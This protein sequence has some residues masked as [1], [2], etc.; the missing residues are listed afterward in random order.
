MSKVIELRANRA[1]TWEQA[2]KFLDEH[3]DEKGLLSA[4]DTQTYERMEQ[5][6]VDLGHEIERQERLDAME[7]EMQAATS[8]PLT[9]K[10]DGA[11]GEERPEELLT[12]IRRT[13]GTP[14]VRSIPVRSSPMLCRSA[15]IPRA[16]ICARMNMSVV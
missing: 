1:K 14:C 9:S 15:L 6:I 12:S 5:E 4:E 13:S 16:A 11:K 8:K 10:P 7:R 3:R 2:K